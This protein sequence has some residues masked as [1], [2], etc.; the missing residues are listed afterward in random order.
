VGYL[1][2]SLGACFNGDLTYVSVMDQESGAEIA[3]FANPGFSTDSGDY[4]AENLIAYRADLSS[5]L[6]RKLSLQF[7]D[8]GGHDFNFLTLDDIETY[9]SSLPEGLDAVDIKPAFSQNYVTN[10]LANG[11]FAEGLSDWTV[12]KAAAWENASGAWDAWQVSGGYLRSDLGGDAARGLLRSSLFCVEGSGVISLS[13]AAA[14]GARYDKDTY[15]S[16]REA[17]SNQEVYRFANSRHDGVYFVTY[18]L[19]L[20]SCSGDYLYLEIVDN[21]TG[22]YDTIFVDDVV[23]YYA[24]YPSIDFGDM[25]TDLNG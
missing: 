7:V 18:Y 8:L 10:Q 17:G 3:R 13:I 12:S 15:V 20:S 11:D 21:A 6:G 23:T 9:H 14:Q 24:S 5:Y 22:S 16:V 19:D 25:A 1:T 2:F 4:H